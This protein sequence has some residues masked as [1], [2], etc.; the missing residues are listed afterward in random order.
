M[1]EVAAVDWPRAQDALREEVARVVKVL[2]A[3][4]D[5]AA[6]AV[7]RWNLGQVAMHLSQAF[8][9]VPSLARNDLLTIHE[10]LPS[11]AGREGSGLMADIWE[12]GDLT[13]L[14]VDSDPECDPM[15]LAD[16]IEQRA[17]EYLADA[18]GHSPEEL[19]PWLLD[20]TAVTLP[21]LTCH[22]LNET[23]MHGGDIAR[24]DGHS[25]PLDAA[26]AAMVF[27]GFLM[28]VFRAL[29]AHAMVD[30]ERAAGLRAAFDIRI[31][32]GGRYTFVFDDG[33]LTIDGPA[34]RP[35]DCHISAD[36][37]AFL[38]VAWGREGQWGAIAKG[39]LL[40][41]GRKPWLG[42]RFRGLLR[43]P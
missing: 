14:G 16:R 25:W 5:P 24:A 41:W 42:L 36:P 15:V 34:G 21:T 26:H 28:P 7:G 18:A 38:S 6:P 2:R 1:A 39:K 22:L 23:M 8:I 30:Q 3:V 9:V 4:R 10:I 20:G 37:A 27:D 40:A 35:V 43:N 19:R 31:R 33:A 11:L 17:A 29:D 32:G 13:S 12:L